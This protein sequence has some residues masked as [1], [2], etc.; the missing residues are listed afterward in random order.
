V[1]R[2]NRESGDVQDTGADIECARA[3]LGFVP[4]TSLREGLGAELEW[5]TRR[6]AGSLRA[7]AGL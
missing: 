6:A 5:V 4:A 7:V 2:R 3:T 1:R